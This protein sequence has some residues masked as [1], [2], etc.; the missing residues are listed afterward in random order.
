MFPVRWQ[1]GA[2]SLGL[3]PLKGGP[4]LADIVQSFEREQFGDE[5]RAGGRTEDRCDEVASFVNHFVAGHGIFRGAAN[6]TDPFGELRSVGKGQL[7]DG[8]A[9]WTASVDAW[10]REDIDFGALAEHGGISAVIH[11]GIAMNMCAPADL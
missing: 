4:E 6:I 1:W 3:A 8:F 5:S 2:A 9:T 7:D 11:S 10:I